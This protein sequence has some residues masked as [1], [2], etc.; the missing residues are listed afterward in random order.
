[1]K[2]FQDDAAV[3]DTVHAASGDFAVCVGGEDYICY[4]RGAARTPA[5][6]VS[7]VSAR[8]TS[9]FPTTAFDVAVSLY[10]R[11]QLP[12][13]IIMLMLALLRQLTR[14]DRQL[15]LAAFI[16]SIP[17]GADL[18]EMQVWPKFVAWLLLRDL[19]KLPK[20]APEE[21]LLIQVHQA[22]RNV[23]SIIVTDNRDP[24]HWSAVYASLS[25]AQHVLQQ[26]PTAP[27]KWDSRQRRS[28]DEQ[29]LASV[30][31]TLGLLNQRVDGDPYFIE[32]LVTVAMATTPIEEQA[33]TLNV[34]VRGSQ[35]K[36]YLD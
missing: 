33:E 32:G 34:F 28:Y 11:L 18:D 36:G 6:L 15:W 26:L 16:Q 29:L 9:L 24:D 2:A 14:Q 12:D 35:P 13:T 17:V 25:E 31:M 5:E 20:G 23:T 7:F 19:P 10:D 21:A 1:M 8:L 22:I 30:N 4:L 27:S 3:R